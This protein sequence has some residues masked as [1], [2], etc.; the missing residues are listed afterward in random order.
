MGRQLII[1]CGVPGAGKSTLAL[2]LVDRWGAASFAS[3]A[4]ADA[5]GAAGRTSSG[6][7]TEQAIAHAYSA[8]AAAVAASIATSKLVLAVGSFRALDQRT[9]FR[10]IASSAGASVTT[11]RISCPIDTAAERVRLRIASGERGPTEK[12]MQRIDAELSRASD[13]DVVLT[14][15]TSIEHFHR[16][17]DI[18]MECLVWGS[19]IDP[20][21]AAAFVERFEELAAFEFA[22][23]RN[24]IEPKRS[25]MAPRTRNEI[26]SVIEQELQRS[27]VRIRELRN[28]L[29]LGLPR[30]IES[31]I[32]TALQEAADKWVKAVDRLGAIE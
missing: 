7:L 16:R 1:L 18:I 10:D 5:L 24:L 8:M 29:L 30:P 23:T 26:D 31:N 6:D 28:C 12:A 13:I 4:F 19:D 2:H 25:R 20:P 22:V 14:N 15:D 32:E 27:R 3:E 21:A 9:R 17:A 11:L